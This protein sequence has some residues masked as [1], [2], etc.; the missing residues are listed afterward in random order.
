M[1]TSILFGTETGNA[2]MCADSIASYLRTSGEAETH[3]MSEA[4]INL[5]DDP[6]FYV[7]VTSTFGEGELPAGTD[8]F[9]KSLARAAPDLSHVRFAVF[10][11][12]DSY[13]EGTFN[14]GGCII[15]E[16]LLS[17]GATLVGE[18]GRYDT[19]TGEPPEDSAREWI[20]T[21]N[22]LQDA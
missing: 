11:L 5:L 3:D 18:L 9:F 7:F 19:S 21:V 8:L 2:E 16:E 1:K 22:V 20:Q 15:V 12:G 13:Y 4:D 17:L 10:G 14:Q 6:G